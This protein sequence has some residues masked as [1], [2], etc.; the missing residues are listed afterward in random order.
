MAL[1]VINGVSVQTP[2]IYNPGHMDITNAERNAQ[3]DMLIDLISRKRKLELEWVN[4]SDIE[5]RK[6]MN[7]IDPITFNVKY[8]DPQYGITTRT[9][10]KGDRTLGMYMFND[11]E[12]IYSSFK[13]NLIEQ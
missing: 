13:V 1:L 8:Y 7:A 6:I 3:G 5:V 2:K 11:G 4:I 9:F 10:Y 12:P